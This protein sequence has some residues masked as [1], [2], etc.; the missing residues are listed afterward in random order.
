MNIFVTDIGDKLYFV[1]IFRKINKSDQS[2]L[3][4]NILSLLSGLIF[5]S[6]FYTY[7][8]GLSPAYFA[9]QISPAR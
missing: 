5:L 9:G 2:L 6:D 7:F 4:I 1:L 8:S 3:L